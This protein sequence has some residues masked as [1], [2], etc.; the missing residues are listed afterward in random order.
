MTFLNLKIFPSGVNLIGLHYMFWIHSAI[1]V[2]TCV[3]AAFVLPDTQGKSL[4]E[5]SNLY[6]KKP[7]PVERVFTGAKSAPV[8]ANRTKLPEVGF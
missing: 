4:E 7:S 1:C 3:L 8:N 6:Q 2:G 5:L